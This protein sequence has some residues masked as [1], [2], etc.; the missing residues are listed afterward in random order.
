[1]GLFDSP[2][3][4]WIK[5]HTNTPWNSLFTS[6]GQDDVMITKLMVYEA[7]SFADRIL[8]SDAFTNS[9]LAIRVESILLAK[10]QF[11]HLV[12]KSATVHNLFYGYIHE[13]W[14]NHYHEDLETA[15]LALNLMRTQE[16]WY[17]KRYYDYY[18]DKKGNFAPVIKEYCYQAAK[19]TT[20]EGEPILKCSREELHQYAAKLLMDMHVEFMC[21]VK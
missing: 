3:E 13:L 6:L 14:T 7:V 10:M 16:E 15:N 20:T 8:D 9:N 4:K 18:S 1:M 17:L 2:Q 11:Y 19:N 12:T 21:E 5:K